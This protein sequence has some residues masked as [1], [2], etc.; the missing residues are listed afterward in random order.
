MA[1]TLRMVVVGEGG[2]AVVVVETRRLSAKT[3]SD[4]KTEADS[5]PWVVDERISFNSLEIVDQTGAVVARR[6][7]AGKNIY[8][9]WSDG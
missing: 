1:F 3:V 6:R 5:K 8:A 2:K 7:Y 9:P 4:A